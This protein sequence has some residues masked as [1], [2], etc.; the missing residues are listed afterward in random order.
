MIFPSTSSR[1]ILYAKLFERRIWFIEL[2]EQWKV[3][4]YLTPSQIDDAWPGLRTRENKIEDVDE[5]HALPDAA[6]FI[7]FFRVM[8]RNIWWISKRWTDEHESSSQENVF[9]F[10]VFREYSNS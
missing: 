8:E 10:T 3:E 2:F 6:P 9:S 7:F 1:R 4:W 5:G